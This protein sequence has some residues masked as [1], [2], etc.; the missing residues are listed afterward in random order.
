MHPRA[1]LA[2]TFLVLAPSLHAGDEAV[3]LAMLT[4]IRLE[5]INNSKVMDSFSRLTDV[6]G[7]RLT[8]SPQLKQANDWTREQLAEW[9]LA[10]AHLESWGPFGPGWSVERT[11]VHLVAPA[12]APL[13]ALPKAWTPGTPGPIRA[14][15][16]RLLAES[17]ADLAQYKGKL[18]GKIVLVGEAR[19]LADGSKPLSSRLRDQELDELRRPDLEPAK[20]ARERR[21]AQLRLG[22]AIDRFLAEEGALAQVSPSAGDVAVSVALGG[23]P[24]TDNGAKLPALVLQAEHYNRLVRLL[25]RGSDPELE[26]DVRVRAHAQDL[27]AYNTVA[28]IPGSDPKAEIVMLGAHLDSWH[29]GTGATDNAS[30]SAVALE[31]MRILK[32]LDVRPRRTIRIALWSGEEQGLLGSRAYVSEH[33]GSRATSTDPQEADLPVSLRKRD[34]PLTLK[35][36]HGRLSVYFN[37]DNGAGRIRGIYAQSNVAAAAVLGAWL[38][39]LGDLGASTVTLR[40]TGRTDMVPFDEVGLPGFEFIQDP[41]DYESRTHHTNLD[42]YERVHREDLVQA[43]IV[44][45]AVVW[46]AA[47]RDKPFPRKPLPK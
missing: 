40:N 43:S 1:L 22:R 34:G 44:M 32:A 26:I 47:T 10:N 38:A 35:P 46:E 21:I 29:G 27:M 30:G 13:I 11:A 18:G 25:E 3:D 45:A 16:A 8:A 19:E 42:V 41:L 6:I 9:G 14:K 12:V 2:V 5:A 24:S 28:E 15:L 17:E 39:P 20:P 7:P 37:L 4:R 33:F 36:D 31:V 23:L